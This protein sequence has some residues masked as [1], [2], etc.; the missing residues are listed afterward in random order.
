[1]YAATDG[2]YTLILLEDYDPMNPRKDYDNLG[3]MVCW[4]RHYALG[5]D[6]KFDSPKDF[7]RE[8]YRNS[9]TD[10]A[11]R[12][13]R[14]LKENKARGAYLEYNH[15]THEWDLYGYCCWRTVFG[16]SEPEWEVLESA[17]K[18]QLN[19]QGWFFDTMLDALTIDDLKELLSEREDIVILPLYLYDHS[20]Q[21]ISTGSFIG[22]AQHAEWDSGQVGYIYAD[23]DAILKAYAS[24]DLDS[25]QKAAE[26][27]EAETEAYD[28]YLRGECY[29]FRLYEDGAEVDSCWGFLGDF[30]TVCESVRECIPDCYALINRL[31]Y[32]CESEETYLQN[33]SAA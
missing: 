5:D 13:I 32:T 23:R 8:L 17:P 31:E 2:K 1:M 9:I 18:S 33:H 30:N 14:F 26:V 20:I 22:R 3:R 21:S 7:L 12:L 11:Q 15:R 10:D 29:G 19:G 27:L 4:H 16:N 6:H 25:V 28:M 24:I